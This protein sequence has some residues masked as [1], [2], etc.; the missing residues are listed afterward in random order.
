MLKDFE[1]IV[2]G[3]IHTTNAASQRQAQEHIRFYAA[4]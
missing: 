3:G 1:V 4:L 2:L